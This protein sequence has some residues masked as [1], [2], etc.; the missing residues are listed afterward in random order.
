V[1]CVLSVVCYFVR[2]V[3]VVSYIQLNNNNNNNN[4]SRGSIV[5]WRAAGRR[6]GLTSPPSMKRLSRE[7][8]SLDVSQAYWHPQPVAGTVCSRSKE[9]VRVNVNQIK[10]VNCYNDAEQNTFTQAGYKGVQCIPSVTGRPP[11]ESS[12]RNFGSW[13]STHKARSSYGRPPEYLWYSTVSLRGIWRALWRDA[14]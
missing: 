6:V 5:G 11:G 1:S 2:Y 10:V 13:A 3:C 9:S 14:V 7:C 4:V 8:G 12:R